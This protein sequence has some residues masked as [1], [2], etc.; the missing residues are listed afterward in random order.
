VL[1]RLGLQ[2]ELSAEAEEAGCRIRYNKSWNGQ[3][4]DY[5][6]GADGALS[7]VAKS[8]KI[9]RHYIH[10][11]QI[12]A[13][14]SKRIEPDFVELYFGRFAPGFFGWMIPFDDR[15]AEIGLGVSKGNPKVMFDRF[16]KR[17]DVKKVHAVQSALIP[18]FDPRQKTVIDNRAIVGDAAGQ[19]KASTGGGIIFGCKCAEVLAESIEK[20]NLRSYEKEWRKKYEL[21]LRMHLWMR[22]F[23]DKADYDALFSRIKKHN[24]G[25]LIERYG[26]MDHPRELAKQILR[27]PRLWFPMLRMFTQKSI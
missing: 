14:L 1:D 23:L 5:I 2:K 9:E 21:D 11:Y 4:D 26:D 27:R 20:D 12:K 13:E 10:A 15:K 22:N 24:I 8:M 18:V 19:V 25:G 7:A 3:N 17:F 16:A 6:I